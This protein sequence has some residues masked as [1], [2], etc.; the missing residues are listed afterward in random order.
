MTD[1]KRRAGT[2]QPDI[3]D[4]AVI[5]DCRTAALVSRGGSIDWYCLP[6]F[7]SASVFGALLDTDRGGRFRVAP[8][9]DYR[10]ERRYAPDTN[11]LETT[12]R[13][14]TGTVRLTDAMILTGLHPARDGLT[15]DHEILRRVECLAGEVEIETLC[16]PRFDYGRRAPD[17]RRAGRFGIQFGGGSDILLLRSDIPLEPTGSAG[18][19]TGRATLRCGDRAYLSLTSEHAGPVAAAPL[20]AAADERLGQTRDWWREWV[21]RS[22][23]R[24]PH[25]EQVVRSLLALKLLVYPPSGAMLAAATTS[26]PEDPGGVRNWDYRFCWL[27]D[28]SLTL[29]ALLHLGFTEEG[30]AFLGWLLGATRLTAPEFQVVYDVHGRTDRPES[31]L[32]HLAGY[33]GSRPVRIGNGAVHQFQLDLYGEVARSAW[34]FVQRGGELDHSE[35]ALLGQVAEVV[36]DSW[37]EPDNGI[38]EVADPRRHYTHSRAL[39]W[40]ALRCILDLALDGRIRLRRPHSVVRREMEAIRRWVEENTWSP[41]VDSYVAWD[42]SNEVDAALLLL[43][44]MGYAEPGS[45]RMTATLDRVRE[46]LGSNG[47]LY[48]YRYDDGLPPG[49][50]AFHACSFWEARLLAMQRR[51]D[52]AERVLEHAASFAND[53]GL[54]AEQ[55]DPRSGALLGNF[56]QA[57][58]HVGLISAAVEIARA[59]GDAPDER[60][61]APETTRP[62]TASEAG[63]T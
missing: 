34:V 39:C 10:S 15:A 17:A 9:A 37:R 45:D 28:A 25:R 63:Q 24:G 55:L 8:V 43:G 44:V 30:E 53:V 29:E 52:E 59:R 60:A 62:A 61:R 2:D 22:S 5:G 19:W 13:T 1:A 47:L 35:A 50:G 4:Y 20:G 21:S 51:T 46:R 54:M 27:R 14:D 57:F 33:R 41:E 23:Y 26:L 36:C 31:D 7:D 32:E 18:A 58:S 56:P 12:F 3:G 49:E 48:R 40:V 42:G 11:V 16:D 38:W 6:R